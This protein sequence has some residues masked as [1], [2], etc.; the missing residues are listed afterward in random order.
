MKLATCKLK[1]TTPYSSSRFHNTPKPDKISHDEHEKNTWR[2]KCHADKDGNVYI[3]QMA[4]KKSIEEAASYR[5][6]KIKGK[7]NAT[8]A[9]HFKAGIM[10]ADPIFVG[11]KKSE[12]TCEHFLCDAQGRPNGTS[13]VMRTFP[14]VPQWEGILVVEVLDD[15]IDKETFEK[16]LREAGRFI[17]VGRFR[18]RNGGFYGRFNVESVTWTEI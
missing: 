16:T 7:G 13:R 9:K 15:Q 8:W 3:P 17:G 10:I 1:S 4:F 18:P 14:V 6:D 2:E 5:G 12:I 11:I